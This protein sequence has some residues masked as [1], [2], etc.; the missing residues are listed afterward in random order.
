M[1]FSRYGPSILTAS[2]ESCS[3]LELAAA[4]G[5]LDTVTLLFENLDTVT[6]FFG[7]VCYIGLMQVRLIVEEGGRGVVELADQC[8]RIRLDRLMPLEVHPSFGSLII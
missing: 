7:S 3:P 1:Q 2:F 4:E 6:I 5:H 8:E